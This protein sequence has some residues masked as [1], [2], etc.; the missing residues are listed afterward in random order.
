[1]AELESTVSD[2]LGIEKGNFV[3]EKIG[4]GLY[5]LEFFFSSM[6]GRTFNK[7]KARRLLEQTVLLKLMS[8]KVIVSGSALQITR[9][10][11]ESTKAEK[12]VKIEDMGEAAIA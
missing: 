11:K 7:R 5:K 1:M 9:L 6:N 4:E 8:N 10:L 12:N 2:F 3:L